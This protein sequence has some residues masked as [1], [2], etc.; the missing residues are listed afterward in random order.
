M[1]SSIRCGI[2]YLGA[3]H[4]ATSSSLEVDGTHGYDI[5]EGNVWGHAI[6]ETV[7]NKTM[8]VIGNTESRFQLDH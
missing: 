4:A 5:L 2:E 6:L 7:A 1:T 8:R 3:G